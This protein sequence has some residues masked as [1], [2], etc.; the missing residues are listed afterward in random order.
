[1]VMMN[2][3]GL[4]P[5]GNCPVQADGTVNGNPAYFHARGDGWSFAVSLPGVDPV[6]IDAA[7]DAGAIY[8]R[9]GYWGAWPDA[10][11]MTEA[12]AAA[13]ISDCVA[14]MGGAPWP[15]R[16][17]GRLELILRGLPN[18]VLGWFGRVPRWCRP[19]AWMLFRAWRLTAWLVGPIVRALALRRGAGNREEG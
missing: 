17:A 5:Y 11:W 9:H 10:G 12:E 14:E 4:I 2:T 6:D 1:M 7:T 15:R 16:H 18:V 19:V 3:E 13:L 8:C